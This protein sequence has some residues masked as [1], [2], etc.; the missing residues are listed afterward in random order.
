[1]KTNKVLLPGMLASMM[2]AACANE[3]MIPQQNAGEPVQDLG[4]RPYVGVV[5]L[6][7]GSQSATRADMGANFNDIEWTS[8]DK[9]GAR[10]IDTRNGSGKACHAEHNYTVSEYAWSNYR[11]LNLTGNQQADMVLKALL[12]QCEYLNMS[13]PDWRK[14][15]MELVLKDKQTNLLQWMVSMFGNL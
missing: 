9:I 8:V 15:Q 7:F 11:S 5:D 13:M 6:N 1:M 14:G 12:G 4:S 10:I 2:F 3:E